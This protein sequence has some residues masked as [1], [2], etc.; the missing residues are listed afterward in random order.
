MGRWIANVAAGWLVMRLTDAAAGVGFLAVAM[1]I[2]GLVVA[3]F[4]GQLIDRVHLRLVATFVWGL[5]AVPSVILGTLSHYGRIT[6]VVVYAMAALASIPTVI[7]SSFASRLLTASVPDELERDSI[8]K[9]S[10]PNS[11]ARTVGAIL[12]GALI[13]WVGIAIT[14]WVVAVTAIGTGV[15]YATLPRA[16]WDRSREHIREDSAED[17]AGEEGLREHSRSREDDGAIGD[18]EDP[19]AAQGSPAADAARPKVRQALEVPM[20][21]IALYSAILFWLLV[22]PLQRLAAAVAS[23]HNE[24]ANSVGALGAAAGL[25][26]IIANPALRRMI[27]RGARAVRLMGSAVLI[28]GLALMACSIIGNFW[29]DIATFA[30]IGAAFELSSTTSQ[31]SL[32]RNTP[33]GASGRVNSIVVSASTG[34]AAVGAMVMSWLMDGIGLRWAIGIFGAI[35]IS[36]G[37]HHALRT[38]RLA[39]QEI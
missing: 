37:L 27:D 9:S 5:V 3:P 33:T 19:S 4:G 24:S 1:M 12:G 20:V 38:A 2:P 17:D 22:T 6:P 10:I 39:D 15:I 23:A 35:A 25:G 16:V 29:Y 14:F 28:G 8:T 36:V 21:R 30:V 11:V 31:A 26:A 32:Q 18:A 13:G 7:A 34:A